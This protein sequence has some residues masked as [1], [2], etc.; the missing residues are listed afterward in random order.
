MDFSVA[1]LVSFAVALVL[2]VWAGKSA[3]GNPLGVLIDGRGRFSLTHLQLTMWTLLVLATF[4]G[5]FFSTWKIPDIPQTLLVLLGLASGGAVASG[6]VKA[7]K[8]LDP[9]ANVARAG[10]QD[11]SDGS[12][13]TIS[14]KLSQVFLKEEGD[15][16]DEVVDLPKFQHFLF[17]LVLAVVYV[18]L[19]FQSSAFPDFPPEVLWLLGI[20]HAGHIG[21]KVPNQR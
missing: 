11:R 20:S 6:A 4:T 19:T 1:W 3:K 8:D 7:T 16:A 14:A 17:A 12:Q 9:G 21:A 10:L 13:R 5:A 18:V 15:Q 2:S